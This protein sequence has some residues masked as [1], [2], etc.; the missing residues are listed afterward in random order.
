MKIL[1]ITI[2]S[3]SNTRTSKLLDFTL[4][5][6]DEINT[7]D[8]CINNDYFE[9]VKAS[10][11]SAN[12]VILC[13]NVDDLEYVQNTLFNVSK[14]IS[15]PIM[16]LL[17]SEHSVINDRLVSNIKTQLEALNIIVW[18][19]FLLMSI[20]TAFDNEIGLSDI[21]KRIELCRKVNII[22]YQ[23]LKIKD[24]SIRNCG[25]VRTSKECG[26]EGEY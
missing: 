25:I 10:L 6:F 4:S 23:K 1:G 18:D 7:E 3:L 13:L 22:Q 16:L 14:L 8:Y 2:D 19:Y 11:V 12:V 15:Q 17:C 20:D 26:D 5:Q 21:S 24:S 9:V